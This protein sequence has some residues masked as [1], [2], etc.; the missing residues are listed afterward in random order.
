[1]KEAVEAAVNIASANPLQA[2]A[3][4]DA[5]DEEVRED[6]QE[7][8]NRYNEQNVKDGGIDGSLPEAVLNGALKELLGQE[9]SPE[10]CKRILDMFDDGVE[11]GNGMIEID[12]FNQAALAVEEYLEYQR[13]RR[14]K[15]KRF[16]FIDIRETFQKYNKQNIEDG[17]IDGSLTDKHLHSALTDPRSMQG[18]ELPC[19]F[20]QT[21]RILNTF[22][23]DGNGLTELEEFYAITIEVERY[24]N[25]VERSRLWR[26]VLRLWA[27]GLLAL[28]V[29][30]LPMMPVSGV[31]I[32]YFSELRLSFS[33][34][35]GLLAQLSTNPMFA[36]L[37]ILGVLLSGGG[38]ATGL[39]IGCCATIVESRRQR[40][41]AAAARAAAA[42]GG[43]P[44][45]QERA[46]EAA[47]RVVGR[48]MEALHP[49][50]VLT[51]MEKL[52]GQ[53]S[54][55]TWDDAQKFI[56]KN[57]RD[58]I[59]GEGEMAVFG[60]AAFIGVTDLEER[61]RGDGVEAIRK[62]FYEALKNGHCGQREVDLL[63]YVL[64]EGE[65]TDGTGSHSGAFTPMQWRL[66]E[67][68]KNG[69]TFDDFCKLPETQKLPRHCVL[70]IRLYTTNMFRVLNDPFT[71]NSRPAASSSRGRIPSRSR[72]NS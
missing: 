61:C 34:V 64:C 70:A 42:A 41:A 21:K 43:G 11:G 57:E 56:I 9:I 48:V 55:D 32:F 29:G 66:D 50:R 26:G 12:E 6:I 59:S 17:G 8:F 5:K 69:L 23:E 52:V 28:L 37:I 71:A 10:D 65:Y 40:A 58:L 22:D 20:D 35:P 47:L 15:S 54:D 2:A 67:G 18:L 63:H 7:V 53:H 4:E 45:A 24:L 25:R 51:D 16:S 19:T 38:I 46:R 72:S 60:L 13:D 3:D 30:A 1:M 14:N 44:E 31:T 33:Q 49:K 39:L 62:E 68:R 36:S 27:L